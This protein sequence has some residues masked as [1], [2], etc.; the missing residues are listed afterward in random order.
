MLIKA[1]ISPD[2]EDCAVISLNQKQNLVTNI[3]IFTPIHDDPFILGKIAACN[4]TNDLFAMNATAVLTYSSFL[5]LPTDIPD[6]FPVQMIKGQS[7]FL[8][9]L[10]AKIDGGHT[11][12]NPWP[13][14]GGTASAVI[15]KE[16]MVKKTG[17]KNGDHLI[18]TKPMGIQAI[19]AAYRVLTSNAEFL[20]GLDVQNIHN[21]I[22]LA[23]KMM[24]TSNQKVAQ[25]ITR[26]E[27]RKHVHAL[28][29]VTG[30]GFRVH[31]QEMIGNSN[32]VA[33]IKRL[34][35]IP[36]T[37]ALADMFGYRIREGLAAETAGAM[38]I[39]IDANF[40]EALQHALKQAGVWSM[41]IGQMISAKKDN[42][43]QAEYEL[44]EIH[45]YFA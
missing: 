14:I 2:A 37:I 4:V 18:I 9:E 33:D 7:A 27:F 43:S 29:D 38:L 5:A 6:D 12:M 21:S 13:L 39:G 1:G 26:D 41:D 20:E 31:L 8:H 11:I 42:P 36:L 45:D 19:M 34:P 22:N 3:D 25:T 10:G 23:V 28:T 32:L 40:S 30:F 24:T 15:E 17:L 35:V 44:I 16:L